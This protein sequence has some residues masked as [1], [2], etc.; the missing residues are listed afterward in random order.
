MAT[1]LPKIYSCIVCNKNLEEEHFYIRK[2]KRKDGTLSNE[3]RSH[4][5]SCQKIRSKE[6]QNKN[7]ISFMWSSAKSRAK[8]ENLPFNI[9]KSDIKIPE[10]CPILKFELKKSIG[11]ANK[12]SPTLDKIIPSLGYVKGN[13][14][15]I[16]YMANIMKSN[17]TPEEILSF[18]EWAFK[19]FRKE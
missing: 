13:I 8:S 15:V 3:R 18:C 1:I 11:N 16:S 7:P 19:T 4:C 9:E 2:R 17:A 10:K 12:N 5:N 14:Q 6:W